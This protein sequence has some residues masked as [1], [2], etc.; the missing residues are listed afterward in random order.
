MSLF[1]RPNFGKI[2]GWN[3]MM[4]TPV[5]GNASIGHLDCESQSPLERTPAFLGC[6]LIFAD[7]GVPDVEL[8]FN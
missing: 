6:G 5:S 8:C 2:S 4:F 3:A 7:P 1:D